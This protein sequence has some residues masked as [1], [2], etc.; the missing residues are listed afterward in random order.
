MGSEEQLLTPAAAP[1]ARG[2]RRV[3][4]VEDSPAVGDLVSHVL[5]AAG[6]EVVHVPSVA[7]AL[8]ALAD[9]RFDVVIADLR[10]PDGRGEEIIEAARARSAQL[11]IVVTT[12]EAEDIEGADV[13]VTKPFSTEDLKAGILR[14]VERRREAG[15]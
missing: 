1:A 3:L 4:L 6:Y 9:R 2:G 10:L 7:E 15:R 5:D 11:P 13:V 12:G 14:A 8:A